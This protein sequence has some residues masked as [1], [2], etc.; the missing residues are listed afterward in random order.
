MFQR[1]LIL[2]FIVII[3]VHTIH[4]AAVEVT[5][6]PDDSS[7]DYLARNAKGGVDLACTAKCFKWWSCRIKCLFFCK[8]TR[9]AGCDC[10]KFAWER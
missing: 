4:S 7:N 3:M 6:E 5:E 10:S 8:C 1:F 9:P 2:L